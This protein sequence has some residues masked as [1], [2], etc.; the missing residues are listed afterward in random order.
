MNTETNIEIK[1]RIMASV[2][3]TALGDAMGMPT[4]MWTLEKIQ[5]HFPGGVCELLP[6]QDELDGFVRNFKAGQITDDTENT[7][8]VIKM[9]AE[10]QGKVEAGS[11]VKKLMNWIDTDPNSAFVLGPSTQRAVEEIRSGK[12]MMETGTYGTTNGAAMK[13]SPIGFISNYKNLPEL[14]SNVWQLCLPT[15]NTKSAIGGA[16]AIAA[17]VSYAVAGGKNLEEMMDIAKAAM[18]EGEKKGYPNMGA[19]ML[20]RTNR[21]LEAAK[22]FDEQEF[23]T[24]IYEDIGTGFEMLETVPAALGIIYHCGGSLHRAVRFCANVG[25]DTDTLGAICGGVCGAFSEEVE[26]EFLRVLEETNQI[27]FAEIAEMIAP[28]CPMK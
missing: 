13:I 2:Y 12:D 20:R 28:Y 11:Y 10:N 24:F 21:A 15:H 27:H 6:S 8:M 4:E 17:C 26:E 18:Q 14:V 5:E 3:G 25:G 7:V 19:N 1:N 9:I 22:V 16:S 23:R